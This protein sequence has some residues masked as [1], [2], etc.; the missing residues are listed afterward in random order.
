MVRFPEVDELKI[1]VEGVACGWPEIVGSGTTE[2]SMEDVTG[3]VGCGSRLDVWVCEIN[4]ETSV[5]VE[6]ITCVP[7]VDCVVLN[8]AVDASM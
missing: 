2:G 7:N 5:P 1:V 4:F 8:S 6:A 3:D